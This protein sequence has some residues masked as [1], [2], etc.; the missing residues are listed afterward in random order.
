MNAPPD[1]HIKTRRWIKKAENGLYNAE[2]L[3]GYPKND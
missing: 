1:R 2:Y 3:E